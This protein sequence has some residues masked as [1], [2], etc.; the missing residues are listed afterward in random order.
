MD[1]ITVIASATASFNTLKKGLAMGKDV[2]AMTDTLSKWMSCTSD[3][4]ALEK[5]LS[6]PPIW[7]RMFSKSVEE[8]ALQVFAAARKAK[9]QR[10][11]LKQWISLTLGKSA[12]DDLIATEGKIRKQRQETIYKQRQ[13]RRKLIEWTAWIAMILVATGILY[14]FVMFLKSKAAH[15]L[16]EYVQ[17]RLVGCEK[18]D[19]ARWCVYRGAGNT[20]SSIMLELSEWYPREFMCKYD[21]DAP[22]PPNL[23]E[24]LKAIKESQR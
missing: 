18:I 19:G 10:N 4:E 5:E 11:E 23:R 7:K 21:P 20:Q 9:E 13:K 17:C 8:E 16:P 24:T 12:W 3:L 2:L 6:D 1:P 14:G 22:P 15:A